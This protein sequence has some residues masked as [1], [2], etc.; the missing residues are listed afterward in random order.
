[1][2]KYIAFLCLISILQARDLSVS[3]QPDVLPLHAPLPPEHEATSSFL[4]P[5]NFAPP[6]LRPLPRTPLAAAIPH[7]T[8]VI[9][10]G[11]NDKTL[12]VNTPVYEKHLQHHLLEPFAKPF[13]GIGAQKEGNSYVY[14]NNAASFPDGSV[15]F[16]DDDMSKPFGNVD[17]FSTQSSAKSVGNSLFFPLDSKASAVGNKI[18]YPSTDGQLMPFIK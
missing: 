3:L 15:G 12:S 11:H 2:I 6:L 4:P 14:I 13:E 8:T 7:E 17:I 10:D 1:M 16:V 9:N 5:E 18:Y